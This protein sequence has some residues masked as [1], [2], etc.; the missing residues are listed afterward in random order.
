DFL[1]AIDRS[2]GCTAKDGADCPPQWQNH[3]FKNATRSGGT[4]FG[5]S[6]AAAQ[7]RNDTSQPTDATCGFGQLTDTGRQSMA[8]LGANMRGLYVDALQ[9]LPDTLHSG[10]STSETLYLRTTLYTRAF[11]SLQHTLG[12]LYPGLSA[13]S[14]TLRVHV[15]PSDRDNMFPDFDC[16]G[17]LRQFVKLNSQNAERGKGESQ[18]L[19]QDMLK[20]PSLRAYF[21]TE[22]KPSNARAAISVMDVV[23]PMRSHG[24]PL[25]QG[26]DDDLIERL[27][28]TAVAEYLN[29]AWQ[30][31]AL[32][33]MQIGRLVHELAGNIVDAVQ[34]DRA[35]IAANQKRL[36]I[37]S[38]HDT[39]LA[40]LLAVFGHDAAKRTHDAPA[41]LEWPAFAA[42]M[43][44]ELLK[45]T[46]SPHPT[47]QPAWEQDP[48]HPSADPFKVP[49]DKRVRPTN[50]PKSL[51]QWS[52]GRRGPG[53]TTQINPRATRDYYVRV[54][55][56][57]RVLQLPTC[58][59]P[60]AHHSKMGPS[61]C[62]LDG[63]FKQIA[64][65]ATTEKENRVECLAP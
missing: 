52:S 37:Y 23:A 1:K 26:I 30:S 62:T 61:V 3:I 6:S 34:A 12:G 8:A 48:A 55:Y 16:K 39:T 15:R 38:G 50:V 9:F 19:Y 21:E 27:S 43:R 13:D 10:N 60:G 35:A 22:Y 5:V 49:F 59:D 36:G 31:S 56:N 33:R 32:A 17:M 7:H 29:S 41:G 4:I 65:F 14:P 18:Q 64:R 40:P 63:F 53:P 51:Y 20:I 58:R 44:I 46:A 47:V 28:R 11:E 45:D 42:S 57:D 24:L 25:P 54:W 2:T